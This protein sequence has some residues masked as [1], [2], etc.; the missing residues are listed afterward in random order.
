MQIRKKNNIL[1]FILVPIFLILVLALTYKLYI[2]PQTITKLKAEEPYICKDLL[3]DFHNQLYSEAY[4]SETCSMVDILFD[5]Q[6][7][8]KY[9][10]KIDEIVECAM[11]HDKAKVKYDSIATP[12]EY[13]EFEIEYRSRF[14][15]LDQADAIKIFYGVFG[16]NRVEIAESHV[17][18]ARIETML[19]WADEVISTL[20]IDRDT[21]KCDALRRINNYLI[22]HLQYSE[23]RRISTF[24]SIKTGYAICTDYANL[25]MILARRVGIGCYFYSMPS[26][27]HAVNL[28]YFDDGTIL[29]VDVAWNDTM[30]ILQGTDSINFDYSKQMKSFEAYF[31]IDYQTLIQTHITDKQAP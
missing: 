2:A 4:L 12:A 31:L 23:E 13:L 29:F 21:T 19:D 10:D 30:D 16:G 14:N 1:L 15:F 3:D 27:N 8:S 20:E 26:I 11:R 5:N 22:Y 18:K 25:F 6:S 24:D 28:V 17:R 7:T 9:A